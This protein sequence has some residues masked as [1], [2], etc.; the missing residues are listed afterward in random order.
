[1]GPATSRAEVT[2]PGAEAIET[3]S[4]K[5]SFLEKVGYG[6]GD[7]A[8]NFYW[9]TFLN[10]LS[11]F[12]TDVFG[13][14]AAAT[15]TMFVVVRIPDTCIDPVMGL[16][17]DR[18]QTRWGH[19]RPYLLW[20]CLPMALMGV[21][22]CTTPNLGLQGK[23]VYAYVTYGLIM[24]AYTF[25]NIPYSALMGVI[26]SNSL[27]R[28]SVS[29]FRFV[30]A[31]GGLF[32]VQGLTIPM[33]KRFGHG[34]DQR[35]FQLAMVVY[36]VL[37]IALFLT[38][39]FT[40]RE[41]VQAA[42]RPGDALKDDLRDLVR[43]IPW[44]MVC[45]IGVFAVFY[46]SLRMGAI[47][48]Y[49]KYCVVQPGHLYHFEHTL[50]GYHFKSD[51]G[52][53][54]IASWFMVMGTVGVIFGA[55]MARPLSTFL[56]GKRRAYIIL[57]TMAST[58]TVLFY[59]VPLSNIPLI[60][61]THIA[62]STLFAPTSPLLWAF[63]ADTADY[64]EWKTGR[65]ATGL[66]FSAASFSQKLGWAAGSSLFLWLIGYI[67]FKANVAQPLHVQM[68]I[69]YMMSFYP[70]VVGFLSAGAVLLYKLDDATMVQIER[71]LKQRRPLP[72]SV[73]SV[74]APNREAK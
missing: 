73:D 51:L 66:V 49:F 19:Y 31:Y 42:H 46:I 74:S 41:R 25:I 6:V 27:E 67:G 24:L 16:I 56:G 7:T 35:G 21:A 63:Y 30:L 59:F 33:V 45:F 43:N 57:M 10:F 1:L 15:G 71:D 34:N 29:S 54:A 55:A 8:S 14:P 69:R 70:A 48:Y 52:P 2:K 17:A 44:V 9:Q 28:T 38:T 40:T 36:G 60:F 47:L 32:M 4:S 5:L 22:M 64:S 37:A 53:E 65:R 23:L 12:Y 13:I 62:I 18:T 11:Y 26:S 50:L 72:S 61:A 58:L 68:G 20:G 39:F 3:E